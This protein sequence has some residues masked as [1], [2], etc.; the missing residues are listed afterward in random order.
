MDK[1]ELRELVLQIKEKINSY[2]GSDEDGFIKG[3]MW[4]MYLIEKGKGYAD[5]RVDVGSAGDVECRDCGC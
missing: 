4:A 3:L 1:A 5:K 2:E